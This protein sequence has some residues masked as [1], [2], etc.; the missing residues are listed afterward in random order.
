[1]ATKK[2]MKAQF[3][4]FDEEIEGPWFRIKKET[5]TDFSDRKEYQY[6]KV[7]QNQTQDEKHPY[8]CI[9]GINVA[10]YQNN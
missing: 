7:K 8:L 5:A 3:A 9:N 2:Q 4:L 1:L 10:F 6:T